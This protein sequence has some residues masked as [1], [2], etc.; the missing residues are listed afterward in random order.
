MQRLICPRCHSDG[1]SFW[2]IWLFNFS[3]RI[4]CGACSSELYIQTPARVAG[5][6]F[7]LL[8]ASAA[9][10]FTRAGQGLGFALMLFA[11]VTNF[12][13]THHYVQLL[14]EDPDDSPH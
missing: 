2:R 6:T 11:L 1:L 14:D 12:L 5:G 8:I 10:Y 4:C 3:Q 9:A 7:V 13:L